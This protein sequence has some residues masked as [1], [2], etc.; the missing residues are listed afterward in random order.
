MSGYFLQNLAY[1][2]DYILMAPSPRAANNSLPRL[3]E[4][5]AIVDMNSGNTEHH[6]VT[7]PKGGTHIEKF[8]ESC[9][10][11]SDRNRNP[12]LFLEVKDVRL[13][14]SFHALWRIYLPGP[15]LY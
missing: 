10:T 9:R 1:R 12:G 7:Q 2:L 4:R 3:T 11:N 14:R 15:R 8:S 5:F 13:R 6:R